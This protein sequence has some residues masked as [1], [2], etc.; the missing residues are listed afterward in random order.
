MLRKAHADDET[1]DIPYKVD[2]RSK[3][4]SRTMRRISKRS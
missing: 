3:S 4:P 1:H 2:G